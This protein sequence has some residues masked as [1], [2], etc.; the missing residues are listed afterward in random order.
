[1][2]FLAVFLHF[3]HL[4]APAAVLAPVLWWAGRFLIKKEQKKESKH[5]LALVWWAQIAINFIAGCGVLWVGLVVL[6][7]DGKM[8]TYTA[9][10]LVSATSQWACLGGWRH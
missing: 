6:G 8:L 1:M 2:G 10:V 4:I 9:L 3:L 5:P 7:H